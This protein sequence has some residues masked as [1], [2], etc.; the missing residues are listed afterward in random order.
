[1][2]VKSL[3]APDY[4]FSFDIFHPPSTRSP[5]GKHPPPVRQMSGWVFIVRSLIPHSFASPLHQL[6]T[7]CKS[8]IAKYISHNITWPACA[9]V[10]N[11]LLDFLHGPPYDTDAKMNVS[12]PCISLFIHHFHMN[13]RTSTYVDMH[14]NAIGHD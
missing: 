5:S 12:H 14:R 1:M 9:H 11:N 13:S 2:L 6:H 7:N 3:Q 8:R 4:R 10:C